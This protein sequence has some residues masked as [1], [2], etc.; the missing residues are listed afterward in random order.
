MENN[1]KPA[2][3]TIDMLTVAEKATLQ[4]LVTAANMTE[5]QALTAIAL[6]RQAV[7]QAVA[8]ATAKKPAV[9]KVPEF[10]APVYNMLKV[11]FQ[12]KYNDRKSV[13]TD[14][15]KQIKTDIGLESAAQ[16]AAESELQE[17]QELPVPTGKQAE[18][19]AEKRKVRVQEL[20][21]AIACHKANFETFAN[22]LSEVQKELETAVDSW[23]CKVPDFGTM[24]KYND[25]LAYFE[26]KEGT[27]KAN[28]G[29]TE[30]AEKANKSQLRPKYNLS[31][32]VDIAAAVCKFLN[33]QVPAADAPVQP[34]DAPADAESAGA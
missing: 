18:K 3:L 30:K 5:L 27:A 12:P 15:E 16:T 6:Q 10:S 1:N 8:D 4:V 9:K 19:Q 33:I 20:E 7:S 17:L 26:H 25:I 11:C 24:P 32:A 14:R 31:V 2:V 21:T 29:R 23:E 34:A 13:L 28:S 22:S